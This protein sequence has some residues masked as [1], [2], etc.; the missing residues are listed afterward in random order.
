MALYFYN[1]LIKSH[2][3]KIRQNKVTGTNMMGHPVYQQLT[4][5]YCTN[6]YLS[7]SVDYTQLELL[8]D[9]I[10][11]VPKCS[12]NQLFGLHSKFTINISKYP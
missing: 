6:T 11:I 1:N 12:F 8:D 7:K 4:S 3:R 10:L 5:L 2:F 9:S